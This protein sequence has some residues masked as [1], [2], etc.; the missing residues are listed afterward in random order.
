MCVI[1]ITY[2]NKNL[3]NKFLCIMCTDFLE[4]V[5]V[6]FIIWS[7][8]YLFILSKNDNSYSLHDV[9]KHKVYTVFRTNIWT[10]S[11]KNATSLPRK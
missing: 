5:A 11:L 3:G 1:C 9:L 10:C 8:F 7:T 6:E 2:D 4:F